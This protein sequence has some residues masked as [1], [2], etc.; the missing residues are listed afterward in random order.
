M[1]DW[2]TIE[3]DPGRG[4]AGVFTELIQKIGVK[5]IQVEELY[6]LDDDFSDMKPMYGLIFL[7]KWRPEEDDRPVNVGCDE[8]LFFAR[9][10]ITNACATQ[11]LLSILLN[12]QSDEVDIGPSLRSFKEFVGVMPPDMRGEAISNLDNVRLAHNSFNRPEPFF[13]DKKQYAGPDDD[14]FHFIAYIPFK[15]K[16]YELDGLKAG[17]ICLGEVEEGADWIPAVAPHIQQ[18]IARYAASEIRF[19]LMAVIKDQRVVL[20]DKIDECETRTQTL[21]AMLDGHDDV[22]ADD[23]FTPVPLEDTEGFEQLVYSNDLP[24]LK[25]QLRAERVRKMELV[26]TLEEKESKFA[27]WHSENIRR[28]H[29]YI[30]LCVAILKTLAKEKR[31]EP[32]IDDARQRLGDRARQQQQNKDKTSS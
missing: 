23:S 11:A 28:R 5:N 20:Q 17:P 6:S 24:S 29:N 16:I 4:A 14:V 3:S 12:I 30:P 1:A 13:S 18:R 8:E 27:K 31:L 10:M 15:N 2:C 22:T 32:M 26:P 25:T 21:E 9:Q 19:N 7:F